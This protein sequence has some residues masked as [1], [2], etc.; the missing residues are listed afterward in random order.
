M[1]DTEQ[2]VRALFAAATEDVPAGVDLLRGVRARRAASRVRL[3]AGLATVGS[4]AVVAATA[5]TLTLAPA[6]SALAQLTRAISRTA[7]QSYHF[8]GTTQPLLNGPGTPS[9]AQTAFSGA[10]DPAAAT[11]EETLSTGAQI[12][13]TGGHVYLNPG[14]ALGRQMFPGGKSWLGGPS[15]ASGLPASASPQLKVLAGMLGVAGTSPQTLFSLL[16]SVSNVTS[17]GS[18]SGSGWTGTR[19]AFSDTFA[20]AP[21]VIGPA[22]AHLTGAID[23]DQQGRVRH[24]EAAYTL[25]VTPSAQPQRVR[26]EMTFS[27]FGGRVSVSAPPA[28]DV[29]TP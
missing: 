11:S 2:E 14:R 15:P 13:F 4:A 3:R 1:P 7:G 28:G 5:L 26:I 17:E 24:L 29:F 9:A 6:P 20:L 10:S 22:I 12:R 23:V 21:G 8:S 16:K 25:H 27:D 19:Y 18:V